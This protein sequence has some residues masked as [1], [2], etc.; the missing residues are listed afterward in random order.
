ME[1]QLFSLSKSIRLC[2]K[3]SRLML[4][5]ISLTFETKTPIVSL[6]EIVIR[7]AEC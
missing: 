4:H 2:C 7:L 6:N 1:N 3:I 5:N